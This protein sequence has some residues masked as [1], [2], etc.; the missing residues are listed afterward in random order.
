MHLELPGRH[1]HRVAQALQAGVDLHLQ[2]AH[3]SLEVDALHLARR[4]EEAAHRAQHLLVALHPLAK[5]VHRVV[6][7]LV[8]VFLQH[9]LDL[10]PLALPRRVRDPEC[11]RQHEQRQHGAEHTQ[12]HKRRG[13][14]PAGSAKLLADWNARQLSALTARPDL[15]KEADLREDSRQFL[16]AFGRGVRAGREG[17]ATGVVAIV[18]LFSAGTAGGCARHRPAHR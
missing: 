15:I 18:L 2:I 10:A 3:E 9:P 16:S 4:R 8:E 14:A 11:E 6:H 12:A 7:P 1:Q 13:L 5:D 17:A